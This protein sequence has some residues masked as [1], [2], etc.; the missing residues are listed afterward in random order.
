MAD[1]SANTTS[2]TLAAH[3]RTFLVEGAVLLVLGVLAIILPPFATLAAEIL[4]GWVLLASGVIGLISTW[5]MRGVPGSGW[6]L[7]S[8]LIGIAA[9]AILLTSPLSGAISLT[10]VLAVFLLLE[11]IVSIT[12][13]LAHRS[14][15][16][17]RWLMLL[18]SGVI[19]IVLALVIFAGLPGTASWAIGLMLGINLVTGGGA[20]IAMAL[21]ARGIAAA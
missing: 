6:S 5:R 9:G 12:L 8:A 11:G 18:S 3:W 20:L 14:G 1:V 21:H 2:P 4:I 19:D 15:F 13:A 10:V 7:L 17:N 16:S